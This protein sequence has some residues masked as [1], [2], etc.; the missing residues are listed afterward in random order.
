MNDSTDD[1]NIVKLL[2]L[3][4]CQIGKTK[5]LLEYI[6]YNNLNNINSDINNN[7]NLN[8]S[9]N[10]TAQLDE[11]YIPTSI[12]VYKSEFKINEKDYVLSIADISGNRHDE[13]YI[14]MRNYFYLIEKKVDVILLCFSLVDLNSYSNVTK[15]WFPEIKKFYSNTPILLVGTKCDLKQRV[16]ES[17]LNSTKT[18][19]IN[20]S[21]QAS[22]ISDSKFTLDSKKFSNELIS[23]TTS[24]HSQLTKAKSPV[25]EMKRPISLISKVSRD[26]IFSST[27]DFQNR[28]VDENFKHILNK[29]N[30][31]PPFLTLNEFVKLSLSDENEKDD[32]TRLDS[33]SISL[34]N[35]YINKKQINKLKE[36]VNAKHYF[37]T[38]S[39]DINSIRF[40]MDKAIVT[41]INYHL[42]RDRLPHK[43]SRLNLNESSISANLCETKTDTTEIPVKLDDTIVPSKPKRSDKKSGFIRCFSC[44]RSETNTSLNQI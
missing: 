4:D 5:F 29:L 37:K 8:D 19:S 3:G 18:D 1:N 10:L 24:L 35:Q 13:L 43:S 20:K 30:S 41:A 2:I 40:L 28:L 11:N 26:E 36:A 17:K 31:I 21:I 34:S 23:L 9:L 38:S 14:Q 12:E 33:D 42:K 25:Q 7:K 16:K 39:N 44:T 22:I 27:N 15:K 32:E 6:K